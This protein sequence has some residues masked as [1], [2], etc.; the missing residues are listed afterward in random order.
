MGREG[1]AMGD[2][3]LDGSG[4]VIHVDTERN[5]HHLPDPGSRVFPKRI[6][7]SDEEFTPAKLYESGGDRAHRASTAC[8]LTLNHYM[9][10]R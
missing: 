1:L 4:F 7:V 9:S 6:R 2:K 3:F 8:R 5:Y 10:A